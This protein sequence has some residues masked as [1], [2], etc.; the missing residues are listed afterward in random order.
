MQLTF[1]ED[2]TGTPIALPPEPSEKAAIIGV[3]GSGKSYLAGRM[4]EGWMMAGRRVAVIDPVGIFWGL[5][6]GFDGDPENGMPI[7]IYGG[8]RMD[9]QVP[10][11]AE[12]ARRMVL[13][14]DWSAVF[15]LSVMPFSSVH[16][17]CAEF[18]NALGAMGPRL[19]APLH[20]IVEEAPVLI[21]QTGALSRYSRDC[22]AAFS[23][24]ARVYRNFG[25]GMTVVT[26]RVAVVSKD[27]LTQC[28]TVF[29]MRLAAKLD[30]RALMDWVASNAADVDVD[31]ALKQLSVAQ[32]GHGIVLSPTWGGAA[33]SGRS[34]K[35]LSR[36]TYHPDPRRLAENR[37][38]E[39]RA[40]PE[41]RI[42]GRQR[43][44][45][46]SLGEKLGR[47]AVRVFG[48]QQVA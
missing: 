25:I 2:T 44:W 38:V 28:G 42:I 43:T 45:V 47:A 13:G 29:A 10:Q 17:W 41:S 5:R 18:L 22:K 3:S 14:E 20:L 32:P 26:Q 46:S 8:M 6:T 30:R 12:A 21:P 39:L 40:M 16:W 24:C 33:V 35:A 27:V 48:T 23:Q 34:F 9:E 15:D 19:V 36:S 31:A 7:K 37:V 4:V 11:P 1:G